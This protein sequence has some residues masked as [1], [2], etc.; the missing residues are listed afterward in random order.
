MLGNAIGV[1]A[2]IVFVLAGL[3]AGVWWIARLGPR[4]REFSEA[5]MGVWKDPDLCGRFLPFLGLCALGVVAAIVGFAFGEWP[6][7]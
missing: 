4:M 5:G 6:R 7:T 1:G 3:G 2:L